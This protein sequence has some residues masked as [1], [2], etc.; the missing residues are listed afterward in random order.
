M[1]LFDLL[2]AL[3]FLWYLGVP[4]LIKSTMKIH[5]RPPAQPVT[6][7]YL[8]DDVK[9]YLD[10]IAPKALV[11]GLRAGRVL[12]DGEPG[13][14]ERHAACAA[15]GQ[16]TR[17]PDGQRERVHRQASR[18]QAADDQEPPGVRHEAVERP[19]D[20]DEQRGGPGGV[21]EDGGV[22]HAQR[23]AAEG[24][25]APAQAAHLARGET[26]REPR[27]PSDSVP[28]AGSELAWFADVYEESIV[29]QVGTGYLQVVAGDVTV[30]QPTLGGA[31][32]MT[33]A[34]MWPMKGLRRSAEDRRAED[35]V[36]QCAAAGNVSA[37]ATVRVTSTARRARPRTSQGRLAS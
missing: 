5:A 29:R 3:P 8:P 25:G 34:Q 28:A 18:R 17:G 37:P 20:R 16:P 6:P 33:W 21:Q 2:I 35:Q 14:A 9:D 27:R 19:G 13:D 4:L 22:G 31:Y 7:R 26:G 30:Y 12:R 15:L 36:R 23:D 10:D 1:D 11:A 24:T 32:R